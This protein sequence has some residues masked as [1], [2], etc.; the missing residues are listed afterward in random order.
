MSLK[1][2]T[3]VRRAVGTQ[4]GKRLVRLQGEKE[5]NATER[6]KEDSYR[7][8]AT[9]ARG[10]AKGQLTSK[11]KTAGLELLGPGDVERG[12]HRRNRGK[13]CSG[14]RRPRGIDLW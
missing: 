7:E 14:C 3:Q 11:V 8:V 10:F 6:L 1:G 4:K 13:S 12:I 9:T 5:S 2:R